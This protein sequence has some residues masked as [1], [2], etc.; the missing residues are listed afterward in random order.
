LNGHRRMVVATNA[1]Y[2][3]A[4]RPSQIVLPVVR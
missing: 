2:H 4:G 3:D 1:I